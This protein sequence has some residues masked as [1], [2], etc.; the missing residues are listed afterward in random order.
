MNDENKIYEEFVWSILPKGLEEYFVLE[1]FE[2]NEQ[3]IKLWL[4]EKNKVPE[5]SKEYRGKRIVNTVKKKITID[6]F[7]IKGKRVE[8]VL[9]RRMWKFKDVDRLLKREIPIRKEGTSL[10]K[11]YASFLKE[12]NRK[13][14]LT[15]I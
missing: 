7:L 11:E 8:I 9:T 14:E 15:D 3:K 6:Y 13:F 2:S 4:T 12:I 5:L 10:E 1:N